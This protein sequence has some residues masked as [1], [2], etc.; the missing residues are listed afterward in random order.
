MR[1]RGNKVARSQSVKALRDQ[2]YS[3]VEKAYKNTTSTLYTIG[4]YIYSGLSRM[5]DII[6]DPSYYYNSY[7]GGRPYR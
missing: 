3:I 1:P 2:G 7:A 5:R 6:N 4:S